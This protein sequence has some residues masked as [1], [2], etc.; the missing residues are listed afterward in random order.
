IRNLSDL[1]IAQAGIEFLG[2]LVERGNEKKYVR[3]FLENALFGKGQEPSSDALPSTGWQHA[4]A[5]NVATKRTDKVQNDETGDFR[6]CH[7][8]VRL[9]SAVGNDLVSYLV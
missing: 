4:N 1:L 3:K 9:T 8:N 2:R 6:A 5:L 7:R